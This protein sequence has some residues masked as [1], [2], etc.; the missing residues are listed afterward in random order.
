MKWFGTFQRVA[1]GQVYTSRDGIL[2]GLP[3]ETGFVKVRVDTVEEG[4]STLPI[5]R[6]MK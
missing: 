6:L 5:A 1:K 3:I 2:H 4:C